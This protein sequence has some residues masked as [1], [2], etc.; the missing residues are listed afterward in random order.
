M[1]AY[2][3]LD[4]SDIITAIMEELRVQSTDTVTKNR[5]KRMINMLYLDEIVPATRWYWLYGNT[6]VTHA[7][8]Y[9]SS[10]V[11]VT[12]LSATVT[13]ASAPTS[14]YGDSGSFYNYLFSV[15]QTN[16]IYKITAHTALATTFTLDRPYNGDLNTVATYKIWREELDMPTDFRESIGM[17][18]DQMTKPMEAMGLQEYRKM[19]AQQPKV[20]GRPIRYSTYDFRDPST[21]SGETEADRYRTIKVF[22]AISQF[23][24]N[25]HL[26]YT[27]E[28]SALENDGDE[29]LMPIEDRIVLFY[30]GL[31]LAWGSIGRNPEEAARNRALFESKLSRMMG[32]VQDTMDKPR[33]EPQSTYI[34]TMR[35][36]RIKGLARRGNTGLTGGGQSTYTSPSY[37]SN[38]TING[39]TVQAAIAVDPG[40]LIDGRD[41]SVDG[42]T[43]DAHII[44]AVDAHD[45]SA[46][47]VTPAGT[48]SATDVQAALVELQADIDT[49]NT[50]ASGAI[51]VGN[52]SNVASDVIP[53]GDVTITNAGV[54]AIAAGVIV[55]ADINASAAIAYSKLNLGTSIVNA[56]VNASAAIVTSK[57][58]ATTASRALVS[59]ASG[60]MTAAAATTTTEIGYVNGV[61]SA[62]QT[63]LNTISAAA[64]SSNPYEISN[65]SIATS[66]SSN[67]LT[68][69][70]KQADGST[71][72]ASG[73]GAV[74][75][76][77][78]SSSLTSG[79]YNQRS[80]TGALSLVISSG[81]TLGQANAGESTIYVYLI[82][83]AGTLELAASSTL[84]PEAV[85]LSTTAEGGAG[86]ADSR[87]VVYSTTARSSIPFR[88]IGTII[89]TQTTAGT[90]ASAGTVLAVGNS[91][92]LR[93]INGPTIQKFITGSSTYATSAGTTYIRVRL[94]GAGGGG[95]SS[96]S[97]A[98]NNGVGGGT[99]SFGTT[100]LSATGGSGGLSGTTVAAGGAG[101]L[102]T[103][104]I[105]T[106]MSGSA[107]GGCQFEGIST[108]NLA[109]GP[110]GSSAFGGNGASMQ[111]GV[112]SNAYANSGSGGGGGGNGG[113]LNSSSGGG[114]GAGGF[115]DAIITALN[116]TYA[117]TV[118]AGGAGGSAGTDGFAG[119]NGA[120]GYIEVTEYY[121]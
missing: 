41:I 25:I 60:F 54:T 113:V 81:S 30:G 121:N 96:G 3:L 6:S 4:F 27:K 23:S 57:L 8:Y 69:A 70:L 20:E 87:S 78:R 108:V 71:N 82:D 97:A 65:L 101:S 18:H 47:S 91:Q 93:S 1:A 19:V 36:N 62:I 84:Y 90:W 56:D 34:N 21:G 107:G 74:K 26:D 120:D 106:A 29:P 37:L 77:V 100:L 88:L 31:S 86:A 9:G 102:G 12:P 63:Q 14:S 119:G 61:T 55:D 110:G 103:G 112:G 5:I 94:V 50:L 98:R 2:K 58:A 76:G 104:P 49:Q 111:G 89:N 73:S 115:V 68:I 116:A 85:L 13:F 17:W 79:A 117:Y 46:I 32:K 38:V 24:T 10:T 52:V 118:G 83:N 109:G 16:E 75:V 59:D 51:I 92:N 80:V 114:G 35:G 43:L 28:A 95:S 45:A 66:V 11:A 99:T 53:T 33:I 72:P 44:D 48:L 40:I 7:A 15:D 64:I 22:P 67:A 42:A 39:A 105:G